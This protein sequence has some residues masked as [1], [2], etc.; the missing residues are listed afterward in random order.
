MSIPFEAKAAQGLEHLGLKV[1]QQHLDQVAQQA[2]A[3]QWSYTHFLGYLLD[4]ELKERRRR[5]IELSLQFARF[6]YRK[7][8]DDFDFAAQPSIDRR[9]IEE[10]ATAR[11]TSEGRNV[12]L[13]GPPGVGKTHLAIAMGVRVA[14]LGQRVYFTTA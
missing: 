14:E 11:F 6:P 9:L 5:S 3:G 13:L 4:G 2:A 1:A 8:L 7:S 10:L 12:V